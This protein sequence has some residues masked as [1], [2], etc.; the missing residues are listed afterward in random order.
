M[1][2]AVGYI[3]T[4]SAGNVGFV[5]DSE[6]RQKEAINACAEHYKYEIE[7]DAWFSDPGV[8][9]IDPVD[10]RS[11][12]LTMLTYCA[13]KNIKMVMFED[14]SRLA[15][16]TITLEV[17]F[18][19]L[20]NLEFKLMSAAAP[21][22]FLDDNPTSKLVSTVLCAVGEFERNHTLKRL[23]RARNNVAQIKFRMGIKRTLLNKPKPQGRKSDIERYSALHININFD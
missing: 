23:R 7:N 11:G 17:A 6:Q 15:R 20:T 14:S 19:F 8:S 5:K 18:E 4:S 3:R 21:T 2:P 13:A 9:G 22:Q 1:P 10:T 12:F 16:D